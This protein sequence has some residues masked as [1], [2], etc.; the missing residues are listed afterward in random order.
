MGFPLSPILANLFTGCH[1]KDCL[2]KA[3]VAKPTFCKKYVDNI[4]WLFSLN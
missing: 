4:F 1:E 3:Q 2:E